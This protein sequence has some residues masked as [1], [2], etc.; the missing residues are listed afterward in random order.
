MSAR[1][2]WGVNEGEDLDDTMRTEKVTER[3]SPHSDASS[4]SLTIL[5]NLLLYSINDGRV[6]ETSQ[7]QYTHTHQI[8]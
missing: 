5:S 8:G 6:K 2:E 4:A 1:E 3:E 7:Q